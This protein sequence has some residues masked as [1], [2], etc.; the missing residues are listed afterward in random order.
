MLR[1]LFIVLDQNLKASGNGEEHEVRK[2]AGGVHKDERGNVVAANGDLVGYAYL[3]AREEDLLDLIM[4][5]MNPS[6][7]GT[8]SNN[9]LI[10]LNDTDNDAD[11][12]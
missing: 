9:P 8:M 4:Q 5:K 7:A 11:E 3:C 2:F 6:F 10:D 1:R 12:V